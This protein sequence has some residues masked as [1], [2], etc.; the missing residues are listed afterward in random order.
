MRVLGVDPGLT[1]CGLGVVDALSARRVE[2]VATGVARSA[3]DDDLGRRL[4][5]ISNIVCQWI[6]EYEPQVVALERVFAQHNLTTV[7][8][9][10]QVSGVVLRAAAERNIPVALHTPSEVKR[11]VTGYGGAQ[12]QQVQNMVAKILGL[13]EAPKPAD[14]ADA[15]ALAI[16]HLWRGPALS[17]QYS[18]AS[19][20]F[21]NAAGTGRATPAQKAWLAAEKAARRGTASR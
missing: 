15:L 5:Q 19:G 14:A 10:A 13:T 1:R 12:K 9:T 16:C 3:P 11:A 2:H 8:G 4:V 21:S 7:M 17:P 20:K 6:A 18:Q